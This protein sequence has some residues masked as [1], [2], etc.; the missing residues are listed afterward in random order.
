MWPRRAEEREQHRRGASIL[1]WRWLADGERDIGLKQESEEISGGK[2]LR[3]EKG[4]IAAV[5]GRQV[6]LTPHGGYPFRERGETMGS[7]IV[8]GFRPVTGTFPLP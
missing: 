1:F 5:K 8:R 7:K 2:R 4:K 3:G 6:L